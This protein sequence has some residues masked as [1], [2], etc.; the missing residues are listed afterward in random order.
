MITLT[1]T[2]D[3]ARLLAEALDSH[4][5]WQLSDENYRRDGQVQEPGSDDPGTAGRIMEVRGLVER[6][7]YQDKVMNHLLN[8]LQH[9]SGFVA[10]AKEHDID[11]D[12]G[13]EEE[14]YSLLEYALDEINTAYNLLETKGE[15]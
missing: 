12:V 2:D 13:D 10:W 8:G 9:V 1:L 3:E 4:R 11:L 5:Y 7:T 14:G 15:A 6:L